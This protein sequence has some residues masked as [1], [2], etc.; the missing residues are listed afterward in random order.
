MPNYKAVDR[1][2][3]PIFSQSK[4][5]NNQAEEAS[6]GGTELDI[7]SGIG[8]LLRGARGAGSSA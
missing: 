5:S 3:D 4:S 6:S 8:S 1:R 7:G 2:P